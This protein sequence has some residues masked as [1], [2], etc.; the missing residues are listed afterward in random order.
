MEFKKLHMVGMREKGGSEQDPHFWLMNC[1][2]G[3]VIHGS[4]SQWKRGASMHSIH[5]A[6]SH[7]ELQATMKGRRRCVELGSRRKGNTNERKRTPSPL[8]ESLPWYKNK[9]TYYYYYL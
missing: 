7:R 8:P 9:Q 6:L 4:R 3:S 5:S 2:D 1:V